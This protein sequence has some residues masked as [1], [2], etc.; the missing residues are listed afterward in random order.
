M[1]IAPP[2]DGGVSVFVS[3]FST[4]G[5]SVVAGGSSTLPGG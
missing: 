3:V 4:F 1:L 5:V 2:D